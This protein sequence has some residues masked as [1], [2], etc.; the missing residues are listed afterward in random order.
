VKNEQVPSIHV[1]TKEGIKTGKR[2]VR[3]RGLYRFLTGLAVFM[4][5]LAIAGFVIPYLGIRL[6]PLGLLPFALPG[7]YALAGVLEIMTGLSFADLGDRWNRLKG[8]ER[9]VYGTI[10]VLLIG[11]III[12]TFAMLAEHF[13]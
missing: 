7:A 9:G 11:A 13:L 3:K 2:I 6:T 5:G 4:T 12:F 8:W 10:S 1:D